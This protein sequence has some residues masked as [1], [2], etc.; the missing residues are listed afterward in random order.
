MTGMVERVADAL[1]PFFSSADIAYRE[2]EAAARA[3][4]EAM[5]NPTPAM[6]VAFINATI[7]Q[8]GAEDGLKRG[9]RA[10]ITAAL[11]ETP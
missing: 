11:A 6:E 3:A 4:I 2:H 7:N 10:M 5:R 1:K 9:L 8:W